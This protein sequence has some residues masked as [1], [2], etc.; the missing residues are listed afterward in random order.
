MHLIT[1][2]TRCSRISEWAEPRDTTFPV[3]LRYSGRKLIGKLVSFGPAIHDPSIDNFGVHEKCAHG[4]RVVT[5]PDA[6]REYVPPDMHY[7]CQF[8][9]G[10][11]TL[12]FLQRNVGTDGRPVLLVFIQLGDPRYFDPTYSTQ[13]DGK[14]MN[15]AC[16]VLAAKNLPPGYDCSKRVEP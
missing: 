12:E 13:A 8:T 16:R 7:T 14:E 4:Y 2:G 15:P 6:A 3:V 9:G 1:T 10:G 11:L 5:P